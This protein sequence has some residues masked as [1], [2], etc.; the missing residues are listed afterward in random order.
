M[1]CFLFLVFCF[2]KNLCGFFDYFFLLNWYCLY[3][4]FVLLLVE[5]LLFF[6]ILMLLCDEFF[7]LLNLLFLLLNNLLE[8]IL[9]VFCMLLL[10]YDFLLFLFKVSF[11]LLWGGNIILVFF[12][13]FLY[14]LLG[15]KV[16][17]KY[18]FL[19]L[20]GDD[21][22][23]LFWFVFFMFF[24]VMEGEVMFCGYDIGWFSLYGKNMFSIFLSFKFLF[25][26]MLMLRI[27]LSYFRINFLFLN[28]W[29][30]FLSFLLYKLKCFKICLLDVKFLLKL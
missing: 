14:F 29:I 19:F 21:F 4:F 18:F 24:M 5:S 9:D 28:M 16:F 7:F 23:K 13:K 20:S 22:L 26:E 2:L 1:F 17:F 25:L 15:V 27:F 6:V 3:F 10:K 8:L 30:V 12:L 11:G